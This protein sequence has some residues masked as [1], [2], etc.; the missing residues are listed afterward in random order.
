MDAACGVGMEREKIVKR[1]L[2]AAM[3]VS[4]MAGCATSQFGTGIDLCD[5]NIVSL[6]GNR[7]AASGKY[8]NGCG[9]TYEARHAQVY[10]SR[11]G[12]DF[13]VTQLS[14]TSGDI[15]QSRNSTIFDC[16]SR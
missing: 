7:Y 16:V 4:S 14:S 8:G 1:L 5:S 12:K 15:Y 9:Q 11:M 10:C 3:M 13:R 2:L 6:G